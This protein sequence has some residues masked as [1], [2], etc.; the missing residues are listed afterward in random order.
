MKA[1][2]K[3]YFTAEEMATYDDEMK[4]RAMKTLQANLSVLIKAISEGPATTEFEDDGSAC[5]CVETKNV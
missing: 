2:G 4:E 3:V 1:V 5:I